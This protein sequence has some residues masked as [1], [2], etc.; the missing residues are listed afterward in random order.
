MNVVHLITTICRGGAE[1]Q[2]L[3]LVREQKKLGHKV[4]VY[5]LKDAP[6][7]EFDFN[8]AGATVHHLLLGKNFLRQ[9][10]FFRKAIKGTE[11]IVH[12]HL[13]K[14]ELLASFAVSHN[15]FVISRHNS[16][17][18]FPNAPKLVSKL[19]SNWVSYRSYGCI[20]ISIAVNKYLAE[21]RELFQ[22][23]KQWVIR[24][25]FNPNFSEL[26]SSSKEL[27]VNQ[28]TIGTVARL[29]PQKDLPTL[30]KGFAVYSTNKYG[31]RLQIVGVG[32][33]ENSLKS[34]ADSLDI[35]DKVDWLHRTT[36]VYE[37]MSK[38]D[39]FC[40]TSKYEGFGL[41]LLEA[42]QSKIPIVAARN[43][44]IVEVL[45]EE[46]PFLFTTS[47]YLDL[48]EKLEKLSILKFRREALDYLQERLMLFS[49]QIMAERIEQVYL[50]ARSEHLEGK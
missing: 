33:E 12:A 41:V 3:T 46:Y 5:Y 11:T 24:Y 36:K 35:K 21:N 45:G 23:R 10:Y 17:P 49:P 37:V 15:R 48:V 13:P 26:K 7:L 43:S 29:A 22:K 1:T 9:I 28:T 8:S 32:S 4:S 14:S 50:E 34:L 18:F 16:E 20:S 19:L 2:L 30:L 40:L 44:A 38:M 27:N 42:M 47:D 25:G 31:T 39:I 6:E